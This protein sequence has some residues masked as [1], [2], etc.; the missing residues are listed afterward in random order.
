[1]WKLL[2]LAL[3]AVAHAAYYEELTARQLPEIGRR[4]TTWK[5]GYNKR[6]ANMSKEQLKQLLGAKLDKAPVDAPMV[7]PQTK[8]ATLPTTFDARTQWPEC[9]L[10]GFIRDQAQCGSCWAVSSSAAM[11]DRTCISTSG[12]QVP[13]LSDED[14]MTCCGRQCAPD[15]NG[16]DGGY[17]LAAWEW[18][19]KT[20]VVTGGPYDSNQGCEPYM[21]NP[22]SSSSAK[23]PACSKTC[24]KSYNGQYASDKHKGSTYYAVGNGVTGMQ[25][26]LFSNGPIVSAFTVYE[27]F[28][29]YVS[30]VYQ[31]K[32]G[33]AVGGHAVK[34]V[35][36]GTE[37]DTPYW[38]VANSWN[39]SWGLQGFFKIIRGTDDCGFE[40]SISAGKY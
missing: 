2:V 7:F 14:V 34:I 26:E 9:T 15:G 37:N 17:P 40:S 3:L 36:W 13:Y 33:A 10:I 35:G 31:H 22:E 39:A 24:E 8:P 30:G 21:I 6:L 11:G 25:Q 12:A 16:C 4:A 27:D 23:A 19:S 38:L 29:N 28:Y 18:W 20:G 5:A 1:M 32:Y